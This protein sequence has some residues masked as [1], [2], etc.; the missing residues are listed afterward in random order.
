M[1]QT[2]DRID[3]QIL[4]TMQAGLDLTT[5]ELAERVGLSKTPCWRRIQRLEAAGVVRR[6]VALLDRRAVNVPVTVFVR[7]RTDQHTPEWLEAFSAAVQDIDEIVEAYRMSGET[8]YIL[9]VV[10]P[11]IESFDAVYKRLIAAA[12]MHDVS[13]SFAMEELKYTTA[14]PLK[15]V[16]D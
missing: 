12:P 9:R 6:R 8:D 4:E 1:T 10:V 15:Y 7:I 5:A 2:F 14:V 11:D 3:R 16:G 13:S